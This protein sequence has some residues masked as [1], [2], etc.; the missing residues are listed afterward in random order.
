MTIYTH[1]YEKYEGDVEDY[2]ARSDYVL[3]C[4]YIYRYTVCGNAHDDDADHPDD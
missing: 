2:Y 4:I 3:N 1:Y